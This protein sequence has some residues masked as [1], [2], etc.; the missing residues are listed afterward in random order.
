ML[1]SEALQTDQGSPKEITRSPDRHR[2][3]VSS[4]STE[5]W[6][7]GSGELHSRPGIRESASVPS[8]TVR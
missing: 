3:R 6:Q 8:A 5:V 4:L 2:M 1:R 7:W